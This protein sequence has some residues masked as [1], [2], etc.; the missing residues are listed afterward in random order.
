MQ[1]LKAKECKTLH[2]MGKKKFASYA[3]ERQQDQKKK[4]LTCECYKGYFITSTL[5]FVLKLYLA[6]NIFLNFPGLQTFYWS[7]VSVIGPG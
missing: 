2:V 3:C 4:Q 7:L 6:S 1:L 5:C